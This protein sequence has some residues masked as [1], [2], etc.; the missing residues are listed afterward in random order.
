MKGKT[1]ENIVLGTGVVAIAT[2]SFLMFYDKAGIAAKSVNI[3]FSTGFIIYI[4]YSYILSRNLNGEIYDLKKHVNNLKEEV[5]RLNQTL[6]ERN[7]T[8]ASQKT[9]LALQTKTI[10][11]LQAEAA[12][13]S[14]AL[15]A[16]L[17][18]LETLK[19]QANSE[20]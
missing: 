4:I 3:I 14:A 15:T 9:E 10:A 17:T 1:L 20:E 7:Q 12:E 11:N 6:G 8:I 16:A 19:A 18:E 5:Q 2:A 13:K